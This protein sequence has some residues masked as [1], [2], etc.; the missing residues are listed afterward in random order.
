MKAEEGGQVER[1]REEG[2]EAPDV[3]RSGKDMSKCVYVWRPLGTFLVHEPNTNLKI[4]L[5]LLIQ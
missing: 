3:S 5:L 4:L 2:E 1:E